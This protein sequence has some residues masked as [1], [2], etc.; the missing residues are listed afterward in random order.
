MLRGRALNEFLFGPWHSVLQPTFLCLQEQCKQRVICG[1]TQ[2]FKCNITLLWSM[3][4]LA[5]SSSRQWEQGFV[6]GNQLTGKP[7]P[8]LL[9]TGSHQQPQL[10]LWRTTLTMARVIPLS[11]LHIPVP[12]CWQAGWLAGMAPCTHSK[13]TGLALL[14]M[15]S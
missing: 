7:V 6:A 10:V 3:R 1:R 12:R 9:S 2:L 8:V 15:S 13:S 11:S 5:W 14:R 4:A